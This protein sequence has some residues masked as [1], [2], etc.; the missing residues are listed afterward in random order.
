[1]VNLIDSIRIRRTPRRPTGRNEREFLHH[2][3][4][5]SLHPSE[6][7]AAAATATTPIAALMAG[8]V[9]RDGELVILILRP[10]RWFILL[11]SLRFLAIVAI[12]MILAIILDDKILLRP[13]QCVEVG[14]FLMAGRLMWAILQ[15]MGRYYILTDMRIVRLAGVFNVDIFDC[16]LRRVAR[17]LLETTFKERLCRI[18]SITIVPQD[19]QLSPDQWQM[20]SRPRQVHDQ[21][22][23]AITRAKQ[24]GLSNY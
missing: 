24:G 17:I 3:T 15:W 20:V 11:S 16:P 12:F 19:D 4:P 10:S 14:L 5:Q 2:P 7:G 21:I 1:M 22:L 8:H 9:L 18:G 6:S 13:R 23:A